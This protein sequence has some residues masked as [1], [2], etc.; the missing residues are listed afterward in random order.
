MKALELTR[1]I[2]WRWQ[3]RPNGWEGLKYH[4]FILSEVL[5]R[6]ETM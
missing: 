2:E 6:D 1:E 4:Y 5:E 3:L